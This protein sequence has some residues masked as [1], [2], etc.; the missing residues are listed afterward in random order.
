MTVKIAGMEM[1]TCCEKCKLYDWQEGEC[2]LTHSYVNAGY[3][4]NVDDPRHIRKEARYHTCPLQEVK[5]V[6]K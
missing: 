3:N 5:E 2:F 4:Y 1:P 6:V